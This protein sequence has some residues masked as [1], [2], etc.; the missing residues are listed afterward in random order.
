MNKVMDKDFE[1]TKA[2][3]WKKRDC[4]YNGILWDFRS[5]DLSKEFM[6]RSRYKIKLKIIGKIYS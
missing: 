1:N 3:W 6:L 4:T 5:N 2:G